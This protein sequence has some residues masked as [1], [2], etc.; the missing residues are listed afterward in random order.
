M[1][2][3]LIDDPAAKI[4]FLFFQILAWQARGVKGIEVRKGYSL[5]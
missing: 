3:Q 5:G 1:I 2:L 4:I